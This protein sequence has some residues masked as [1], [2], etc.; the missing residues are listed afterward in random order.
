M[1]NVIALDID[2]CILP[3]NMNYFGETD[4][5]EIMFEVN[6]KRLQM[7]VQKY[8][9]DVFITSSWY[10]MFNFDEN[11][12]SLK[13]HRENVRTVRLF[14]LLMKY[15]GE[16][17]TGISCGNRESDIETLSVDNKV[18]IL[19]DMVLKHLENENCLFCETNGF[20]TGNH[21]YKIK[22]FLTK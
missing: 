3:S 9:M 10:A 22:N 16:N 21:G 4:D 15:V 1:R 7:I 6:L 2:D 18:V 14:N 19:D 20:I 17:I 12:L 11:G 8:D 5:D 13:Y